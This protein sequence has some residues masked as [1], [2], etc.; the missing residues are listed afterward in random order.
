MKNKAIIK[1]VKIGGVFHPAILVLVDAKRNDF[2]IKIIED[3]EPISYSIYEYGNGSYIKG[4]LNKRKSHVTLLVKKNQQ[5]IEAMDFSNSFFQRLKSKFGESDDNFIT[6]VPFCSIIQKKI[7]DQNIEFIY[8]VEE[9]SELVIINDQKVVDYTKTEIGYGIYKAQFPYTNKEKDYLIYVRKFNKLYF[10]SSILMEQQKGRKQVG[11]FHTITSIG[12]QFCKLTGVFFPVLKIK[13]NSKYPN[14][15]MKIKIDNQDWLFDTSCLKDNPFFITTKIPFRSCIIHI[16]V[17]INGEEI[18]FI[19][20]KNS[21]FI[22]VRN[23][24]SFLKKVRNGLVKFI[25]VTGKGIIFLWKEHH[26]LVP[27]S[28]WKTYLKAYINH[29]RK[30]NFPFY[31]PFNKTQYTKWLK[32]N[33]VKEEYTTFDYNPLISILIPVYNVKKEY[34]CACLDSIL[35][36]VYQNFEVCIVDDAST[37]KEVQETLEEYRE[38]DKRIKVKYR[39]ENGHISKSSNDALSMATGEFIALV[40]ND[41]VLTENALYENVKLLNQKKTID[42]I[43]SD[44]DKIDVKG[45]RCEPHF[46]PDYSP[47]TL[48]SLNYICHFTVIRKSL[49]EK[50][51]GFQIGLE[52]AQDY[53]LFLKVVEQTKNIYH[54]PKILYHWRMSETSTSMHLSNKS[55]ANDKGLLAI[56]NALTRRNLTG[57]VKK[58]SIS[59]YYIVDYQLKKY[60]KISIL[61]PTKD[62]ADTLEECLYSLYKLTTYQDFE[63]IVM[64]NQSEKKET[65]KLLDKYKKKY[66][67]FKVIDANFEFNYSK[68]NNVALQASEGEY[69]VLLNNDTKIITPNWLEIMVGYASLPHAGAVGVKLLYP[70]NTIQHAGVILGLGGVA[71]HAYIGSSRKNPGF[72]GRTRV[73]YNYGAVTAACLMVSKKKYEEVGGLEE[74]LKVAYNDVDFNLKL[75]QKGYYNIFLP[76]VELYHFESKSR[77]LDTEGEKYQRFLKESEYMWNKWKPELEKDKFYNPNFSKKY[78][79]VL[80]KDNKQK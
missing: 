65:F 36:Q 33:E 6:E 2:E 73:P 13:G 49:V 41:D 74:E 4:I 29:F 37:I 47:D 8:E 17:E 5:I 69:I 46:K 11:E 78:W 35:N 51:G 70:D 3:E 64:N 72:Y 12:I 21:F 67:N 16:L 58:D 44:E 32:N 28:L 31:N 61:I 10:I 50:V 76:Q 18:E 55:Y 57:Q 52:G 22:R 48:L 71:S 14:P 60:P 27:P 15:T 25:T 40:D 43:Y 23:K 56:S 75:A 68:I 77:G 20:L 66:S 26:F 19:T 34:L 38:K 53:D 62:Y 54:I 7:K 63:V 79:F 30:N 9:D 80:E 24:F 45:E 39:T 42:M 1:D 59:N